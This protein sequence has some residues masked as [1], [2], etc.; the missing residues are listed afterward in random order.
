M[1]FT[2]LGITGY[3]YGLILAI[4][5]LA[6]LCTAGILGY[7][8]R[9]PAGT[10]RVFGLIALPVSLVFARAAFCV[11]NWAYFTETISQ[12]IRMLSF[13][14]GGLSLVGALCGVVLAAFLTARVMKVRFGVLFDVT[15]VPLGLMIAGFRLAE[16]VTG[17]LGVGRQVEV[18]A[19]VE[20]LPV[21]FLTEQMGT[22]TLHRLA[23]FRYEA[24]VA[25]VLFAVALWFF[26]AK[27][28]RRKPRHG[29]VGMIVYALLG[30]SQVLLES[31]RDDGHMLL[32]FIRMQQ[33]GFVL[34]PLLALLVLSI[35][36][37]HIREAKGA[38]V[39]AWVLL[40]L[41]ALIA[42]LMI[43]PINHVLDLTNHRAVGFACL[44]ALG[45]YMALFL[46][47]RGANIRLI[48]TWLMALVAVAGCVMVE[49]SIDGSDNLIRDYAGMA[50]CCAL[51][52]FAPY[53]LWTSLKGR[54]YRE[55]SI[56]VR[57]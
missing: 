24:F 4:S 39:T 26:F 36:Y 27:G 5:V 8:R 34:M 33:L 2:F 32:G 1:T 41:M 35:R 42:L 6:Y 21:L 25:L 56:T 31:L 10:V 57:I 53:T 29:D 9:L 43:H 37:G 44:A 47:V 55:E 52:Y 22:L 49:F 45:V 11:V 19:L 40:P 7:V 30:S 28:T 14:D 23:V 46:R 12:P 51:L 16:G 18:D 13:W 15:A 3:Q 20:R 38:T 48:L 17:Q 54:V 50:F